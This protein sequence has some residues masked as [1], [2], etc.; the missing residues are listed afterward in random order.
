MAGKT[1]Y[2]DELK[3]TS[4]YEVSFIKDDVKLTRVFDSEYQARMFTNKIKRS[5]QCHLV[6]YP[7]FNK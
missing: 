4:Y 7:L 2:T 5:K 6:S 3:P 1:Y